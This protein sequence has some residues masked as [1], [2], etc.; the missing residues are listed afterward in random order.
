MAFKAAVDAFEAGILQAKADAATAAASNSAKDDLRVP[1]EDMLRLRKAYVQK[2]SGGLE[3]KILAVG[4]GVKALATPIGDL[5]APENLRATF[6]DSAG[7]IDL[8]WDRVRGASS[9]LIEMRE[10]GTTAWIAAEPS[11]K[12]RSTVEGLTPGKTYEFRVRA[13]GAAGPG[14]WSSVASKMAP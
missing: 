10:S 1:V 9:Y 13:L 2:K 5:L 11:T 4:L 14:P 6:G 3:T 12:S 7:E 8:S